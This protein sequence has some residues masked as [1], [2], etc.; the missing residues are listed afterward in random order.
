MRY[1]ALL[2]TLALA[3][4]VAGCSQ[5][6]DTP[7]KYSFT[8]APK[9]SNV[10]VTGVPGEPGVYDVTWDVDDDTAVANYRIY[11]FDPFTG[12]PELVGE[13]TTPSAQVVVGLEIGGLAFGVTAVTV[14]NVE[15]AM[16]VGVTPDP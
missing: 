12:A 7:T 10:Q 2:A 3:V 6:S 1:F 11:V 14:E 13:P 15:G 5:H 16:A 8:P 4:F 9:V